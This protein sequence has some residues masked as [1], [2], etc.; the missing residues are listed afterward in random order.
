[1]FAFFKNKHWLYFSLQ[2]HEHTKMKSNEVNVTEIFNKTK[3]TKNKKKK[4]IN[5]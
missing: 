4:K 2:I 3:Q 5:K 1:M